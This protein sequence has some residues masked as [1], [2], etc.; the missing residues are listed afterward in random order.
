LQ[1]TKAAKYYGGIADS[2]P[3]YHSKLNFIP[4][5]RKRSF[6][7][8]NFRIWKMIVL[9][10]KLS[11]VIQIRPWLIVEYPF[12]PSPTPTCCSLLTARNPWLPL[13]LTVV[14]VSTKADPSSM[15]SP[16]RP[17]PPVWRPAALPNP[18]HQHHLL[19]RRARILGATVAEAGHGWGV[20]RSVKEAR[21]SCS[22]SGEDDLQLCSPTARGA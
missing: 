6:W 12:Y 10:L 17:A 2:I 9:V 19:C 4:E 5:L 15:A 14:V 21:G 1:N 11:H 20:A 22:I 8:S 7:S 16:R 3:N 18:P 13:L